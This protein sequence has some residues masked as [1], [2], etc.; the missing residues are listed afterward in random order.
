MIEELSILIRLQEI[1]NQQMEIDEEKGDLPEQIEKLRIE[2]AG[3]KTVISEIE[4]RH[5]NNLEDKKR[6]KAELITAKGRLDRAQAI[7]FE[8]KTT[9][10]YDA[11]SSEIEQAKSSIIDLERE[12]ISNNSLIEKSDSNLNEEIAKLQE[13]ETEFKD[14]STEMDSRLDCSREEELAL[15]EERNKCLKKLKRPVVDHYERIRKIRNGI[16]VSYMS[17]D[18]CSYCYSVMPPQRQA[19][20]R[21]MAD[22]I[23]CEVCGCILVTEKDAPNLAFP[24]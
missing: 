24:L 8:V 5:L 3:S 18:A 4:Q 6:L 23:I 7:I 20:V 21:K 9:R 1:D 11:I 17:I 13:M 10:E 14:R 12:L 16:G 2:I 22:M 15:K 19:E